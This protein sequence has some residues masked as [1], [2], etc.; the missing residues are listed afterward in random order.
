MNLIKVWKRCLPLILGL[1][2][3]APAFA[4]YGSGGMGGST[5]TYTPPKGGYGSNTGI[6]VGAAAAAGVG[7][8]YLALR[9]HGT[10]VGCVEPSSDGAKMMNEKDQN[11]YAL[12]AS[13]I[14]LAPG[15]RLVL[16]GKKT[17]DDSGKPAFQ[18]SKL[19]K[20]YG[21]CGSSSAENR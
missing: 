14:A 13:N 17:K 6:I 18:V 16:S 3:A 5:G 8:T 20:D 1:A 10:I 12:I 15:Q 9:H 19:V 21:A 4:Q 2:L 11:T 7:V